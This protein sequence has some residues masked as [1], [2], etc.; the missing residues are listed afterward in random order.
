ML[1]FSF[2]S[3][4]WRCAVRQGLRRFNFLPRI[5]G[6]GYAG[7]PHPGGGKIPP[8]L[9]GGGWGV[10][11][12]RAS[13]RHAAG[14]L[15]CSRCL[16]LAHRSPGA[17]GPQHWSTAM[18]HKKLKTDVERLDHNFDQHETRIFM[19]RGCCTDMSGAINL[20][21]RIDPGVRSVLTFAAGRPDTAYR[22]HEDGLWEAFSHISHARY[23]SCTQQRV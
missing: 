5:P 10:F 11:I 7:G 22:R 19:P 16:P 23:V 9:W 20:A 14:G 4:D 15:A 2:F 13:A 3:R 8:P 17:F 18:H 21:R 12:S 6:P 1:F